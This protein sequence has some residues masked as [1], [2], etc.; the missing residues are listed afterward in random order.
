MQLRNHRP[1]GSA[2]P[3]LLAVGVFS[4]LAVLA[5][6]VEL[7]TT[8]DHDRGFY[9]SPF[10]LAISASAPGAQIIYTTDGSP[11]S[12]SNGSV[13]E[14]PIPIAS[15]TI[16]R[17][18][19]HIAGE[20]FS[21]IDTQTY[22]FIHDVVGQTATIDGY[23][24][25]AYS[26]G[27]DPRDLAIH[28]YQMDPEI[29][30]SETYS[31]PLLAG[32]QAIPSMS[33]AVDP[34]EM[35][36][37]AGFYDGSDVEK[38][39]S[40]EILYP[41]SPDKNEQAETGIESHSHKRLKRSLRLNFRSEYGDS[42]FDSG[43]F[44]S[45]P[46]G[47]ESAV[48]RFDRIIL[49]GGSNRSWA[50][51]NGKKT[52]YALDEFS[53]QSQLAVSGFGLH[54][55]FV[56]LYING[57][58]WGLYNPTERGDH[59]FAAEY[60]GGDSSEW[61]AVNHSGVLNGD[62]SRWNYLKGALKDKDMSIPANYAELCEYLDP[63]AFADYLLIQWF[64]RNNDWPSNN[65]FAISRDSAS[66]MGATPIRFLVWDSEWTWDFEDKSSPGNPPPHDPWV[67]FT[68]NAGAGSYWPD[69]WLIANLF[70]AAKH[71]PDFLRLL[72]DRVYEH[73][74]NDGAMSESEN[75]QRWSVLTDSIRDAVVAE[76]ARWGDSL[77]FLGDPTYTRDG[78]WE[79]EV[80]FISGLM[81][82]RTGKFIAALRAN[83]YYPDIDPP[84][85]SQHGGVISPGIP[86]TMSNPNPGGVIFYTLDGE[87]PASASGQ[88]YTGPLLLNEASDVRARVYS[89]GE[90]SAM[91]RATFVPED[92]PSL[93]ITEIMYHP[94][95]LTVDEL[96][97]GFLND[98][99]F[100]FVELKNVGPSALALGGMKFDIGI[101]FD[102]P[103]VHLA[104]GAYAL[105]V[106]NQAAFEARYGTGHTVLGTYAGQLSN[107]G[108]E[109][110]LKTAF[111]RTIHLF[112]YEDDWYPETDG[113]G[114]S[115]I[116]LNE[117][118]ADFEL[119]DR[120][121]GW[122]AS[123]PNGENPGQGDVSTY[124]D[125]SQLHF[126]PGSPAS[127]QLDDADGDGWSNL[128]EF[129]LNLNPK[130]SETVRPVELTRES[131]HDC[132]WFVR[133]LSKADVTYTAETSADMVNWMPLDDELVS[134]TGSLEQ[135]RACAP[136]D[137]DERKFF[138]LR[139]SGP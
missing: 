131:G 28:D 23:P 84:T 99:D 80:A 122:F 103:D 83:G 101:H 8:F 9:E 52:S 24:N 74:F 120:K 33:I 66:P 11:P 26:V 4:K 50:R 49:R 61:F 16:V 78:H 21:N 46:L 94:T 112:D 113:L 136:V 76:S 1:I 25:P 34:A 40:V 36:G 57:L 115:L 31:G 116:I 81:S 129:A 54:G 125:W 2:A 127:G 110:G 108:E 65:W 96:A 79:P 39:A 91:H 63:T 130:R 32:L 35:F 111:G 62:D 89:D 128:A 100:E 19:A 42:K 69:A 22:L 139:I 55:A 102:F 20:S 56:H 7:D 12:L 59:H 64:T 109:I 14:A 72:G 105:V 67:P 10:A 48:R 73:Y 86:L 51:I 133:D 60:F 71:S 3:F 43:L 17:A 123:V 119:W 5:N 27:G 58:Y 106:A 121:I 68:F 118:A 135:R 87:D 126:S 134:A 117:N 90:W 6:V 82:G 93:R 70:N 38:Q 92:L 104:A 132:L 107:G 114:S 41:E 29:V 98:E 47:A 95:D 77:E 37:E 75:Q 30:G 45:F 85:L 53:R 13:Y 15:T 137:T 18:M 97:A 44:R 88:T 124:G 138:R